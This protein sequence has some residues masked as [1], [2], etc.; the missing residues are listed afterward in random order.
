MENAH[1]RHLPLPTCL[2]N[3]AAQ[4]PFPVVSPTTFDAFVVA[5]IGASTHKMTPLLHAWK[6]ACD[7]VALSQKQS[8]GQR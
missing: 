3:E 2:L 1:T 5:H 7:L 6:A 8:D 4:A